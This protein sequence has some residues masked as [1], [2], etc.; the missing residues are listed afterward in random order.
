VKSPDFVRELLFPGQGDVM[1]LGIEILAKD[2]QIIRVHFSRPFVFTHEGE[3]KGGIHALGGFF[4]L[5]AGRDATEILA[6]NDIDAVTQFGKERDGV[7][8]HRNEQDEEWRK[9]KK[10]SLFHAAKPARTGPP[11]L[12][13]ELQGEMVAVD[14]ESAAEDVP[15]PTEDAPP[16]MQMLGNGRRA[17]FNFHARTL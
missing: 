15:S 16:P 12:V 8:T 3:E 2:R 11:W 9:P 4:H 7:G 10:D 1:H 5:L 14:H 17:E 6:E 13:R